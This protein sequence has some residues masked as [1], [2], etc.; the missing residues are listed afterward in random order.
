MGT[1]TLSP[2]ALARPIF[3][4]QE[5]VLIYHLHIYARKSINCDRRNGRDQDPNAILPDVEGI[6]GIIE[7][8]AQDARSWLAASRTL[9]KRAG[10]VVAEDERRRGLRGPAPVRNALAEIRS[11]AV[12]PRR[13]GCG[14]GRLLVEALLE[15]TRRHKVSCVCLF[16]RTPAFRAHGF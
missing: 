1:S 11:I 10:F 5:T 2:K 16:T 4:L 12:S 14:I 3:P 6:H 9:R 8:Y 7:P 13:K 15:E